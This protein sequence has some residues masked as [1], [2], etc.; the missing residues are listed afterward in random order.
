MKT[1]DWL[2]MGLAAVLL[3]LGTAS[4]EEELN[5]EENTAPVTMESKGR[6]KKNEETQGQS[7][8][9]LM[10]RLGM[11]NPQKARMKKITDEYASKEKKLKATHAAM[12]KELQAQQ[13]AARRA[14]NLERVGEIGLEIN[15]LK[16][17]MVE[18]KKKKVAE[19]EAVLT[20]RQ[21]TKYAKLRAYHRISARFRAAKMTYEQVAKAE[22]IAGER[23]E[24]ILGK[25][26]V[27]ARR[28]SDEVVQKIHG[29]VLTEQQQAKVKIRRPREPKVRKRVVQTERKAVEE[30]TRKKTTPKER[31][32]K[33]KTR[34]KKKSRKR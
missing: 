16:K 7:E 21:K 10:S 6:S 8:K 31:T 20:P 33:K 15:G 28:A 18:L 13:D 27:A 4:A 30:S 1:I 32:T 25:N 17:S 24:E 19:V 22:E 5:D 12:R 23:A 2:M 34:T 26:K 29:E 14:G 3:S 9:R 11:T